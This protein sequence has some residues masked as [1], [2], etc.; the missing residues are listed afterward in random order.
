MVTVN[1]TLVLPGDGPDQRPVPVGISVFRLAGDSI[2]NLGAGGRLH[3]VSGD[4][5]RFSDRCLPGCRRI[6][7]QAVT[8][9]YFSNA[10]WSHAM[11][12]RSIAVILA[13]LLAH[14][15]NTTSA[16]DR[17][18]LPTAA[19]VKPVIILFLDNSEG[20]AAISTAADYR[21]AATYP[22]WQFEPREPMT[23]LREIDG[24]YL[25]ADHLAGGSC[26]PGYT[27]GSLGATWKC[28]RL[29]ATPAGRRLYERHYLQ[30]LFQH[31]E[32]GTDLAETG[33]SGSPGIPTRSRFDILRRSA[34]S[35][36]SK[37]DPSPICLAAFNPDGRLEIVSPCDAS[38]ETLIAAIAAMEVNSATPSPLATVHHEIVRWLQGQEVPGIDLPGNPLRYRCQGIGL[39]MFTD[40]Q[41][42][43]DTA[44]AELTINPRDGTWPPGGG[45]LPDWDGRRPPTHRADYLARS[46]PPFSDGHG[47]DPELA[48]S[49]LYLDDMSSFGREIDLLGESVRDDSGNAFRNAWG[50][51]EPD[52]FR[53]QFLISNVVSPHGYGPVLDEVARAGGGRHESAA[54]APASSRRMLRSLSRHRPR[55]GS[56]S[57]PLLQP[58]GSGGYVVYQ[59]TYDPVNWTG[60]VEAFAADADAIQGGDMTG[61]ALW[62]ASDGIPDHSE[63]IVL[64]SR[65]PDPSIESSDS[66][67]GLPLLWPEL[68]PGQRAQLGND[69]A[70]VEWIRGSTA[71]SASRGGSFP[72]RATAMGAVTHAPPVVLDPEIPG[73][74]ADGDYDAFR[75]SRIAAGHG[76]TLFVSD[77]N[78]L[79]HAFNA[80]PDGGGELFAFMPSTFMREMPN[81]A[82]SEPAYTPLLDGPLVLEDARLDDISGSVGWRTVLMGSLGHGGAGVFALDVS[83]VGSP[84][85]PPGIEELFLWEI[86]TRFPVLAG[87]GTP[88]YPHLGELHSPAP[89]VRLRSDQGEETWLAVIPNGINSETGATV[90]YLVDLADGTRHQEII[91]SAESGGGLNVATAIDLDGDLDVDR[92]YAGDQHGRVWRLDHDPNGL[93]FRSPYSRDG[94]PEPFF[95]APPDP[96]A[97]ESARSIASGFAINDLRGVSPEYGLM[98]Y[99]GT[100]A[101]APAVN[102]IYGVRDEN[103]QVSTGS[104]PLVERRFVETEVAGRRIRTV[105]GTPLSTRRDDMAGWK[106]DLPEPGEF[107]VDTPLRH[108]DRLLFVT[109]QFGDAST[110]DPCLAEPAGWV[111][112]I[113][114]D[115]GLEPSTLVLDVDG[116]GAIDGS[117]LGPGQTVPSGSRIDGESPNMPLMR[118]IGNGPN[119]ALLR[120]EGDTSGQIRARMIPMRPGRIAWRRLEASP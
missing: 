80:E 71:H 52:P 15:S 53:H 112:E 79:L 65:H 29:P 82:L 12:V 108:H 86:N 89:I 9:G 46:L 8:P 92:I 115:S 56:L 97:P 118:R 67:V 114:A 61:S 109:R 4:P 85:G 90:L 91:L 5:D 28:L 11:T 75:Q 87:S 103:Q 62:S 41:A 119:S 2:R 72:D 110:R 40:G 51:S 60:T 24:A 35:W 1:P 117:D 19:P 21:P 43:R 66:M 69:P 20:M 48:G 42:T 25:D 34:L 81:L 93:Y 74:H 10:T 78:G 107:I 54:L 63:R 47:G 6:R 23:S 104:E 18:H 13:C 3:T 83:S 58:D 88:A 102:S 57:A 96:A 14:T 55:S 36:A 38:R 111:L 113:D 101:A 68:N 39:V 26:P 95:Q 50:A 106:L 98:L 76:S 37:L 116:D 27:H 77:N 84:H 59:A 100:T 45:G 33:G 94:D 30:F 49:F 22:S 7:G 17:Y 105:T 44:P 32:S 16:G 64:T 73:H 120:L 70:V 31:F 99:F